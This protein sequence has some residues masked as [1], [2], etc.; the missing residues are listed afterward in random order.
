MCS[1]EHNFPL[2]YP[3]RRVSTKLYQ[4]RDVTMC[5][6]SLKR[7]VS[8]LVWLTRT[9]PCATFDICG[10]VWAGSF[11]CFAH[12]KRPMRCVHYAYEGSVGSSEGRATLKRSSVVFGLGLQSEIDWQVARAPLSSLGPG[13][14]GS[15]FEWQGCWARWAGLRGLRWPIGAGFWREKSFVSGN[16]ILYYLHYFV[17][18]QNWSFT[19]LWSMYARNCAQPIR[20][21]MSSVCQSVARVLRVAG[22]RTQQCYFAVRRR[23]SPWR[24]RQV[25]I[26]RVTTASTCDSAHTRTVALRKVRGTTDHQRCS[27]AA[28]CDAATDTL[29]SMQQTGRSLLY[30][31]IIVVVV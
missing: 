19:H 26:L 20:A 30:T 3:M 15:E 10:H 11:H 16:T 14:G 22:R 23:M 1:F 8:A 21:V 25:G 6:F 4:L 27:P 13:V 7:R 29:S 12:C 28:L 9:P 18:H 2:V 31:S 5:K 24:L 17:S